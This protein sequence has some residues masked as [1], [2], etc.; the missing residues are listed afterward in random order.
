MQ[1]ANRKPYFDS[2]NYHPTTGAMWLEDKFEYEDLIFHIGARADYF[3]AHARALWDPDNFDTGA[4]GLIN[5]KEPGYDAIQNPDPNGDDFD[6]ELNPTGTEG[7]GSVDYKDANAKYQVSPR[8]G[9]SFAVSDKT[10]MYANYGHFFMMPELGEIYQNLYT[11]LTSGLP[12]V[13]NPDIEPQHTTAYEVGIKHTITP[14]LGFEISAFYKDVEN[15]LATRTYNTIFEGNVATVTFQEVEDFAKIKGMDFKLTFRNLYGFTGELNYSYLNAKG[16]GSSNREFYYLYIYEADRPLP[17][18]E[19]PLEFDITHSLKMNINYFVPREKGPQIWGM[20]PFAYFNA[21]LQAVINSGA[22]YTPVDIYDK[23]LELGSRRMPSTSRFDLRV[24]KFFP[25]YKKTV[26]S[27]YADIRNLFNAQNIVNVYPYTGL[28]DDPGR[29]PV[30][31][32]SR[33]Y[34][35]VG[36]TDPTTGRRITTPEEAYEAHMRVRREYYNRPYYYGIPRIVR[37][38][39]SLRF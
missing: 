4:D 5:S 8:F 22:P 19:Y 21:N 7:D 3:H 39:V 26:L 23:P 11:D 34:Q 12:L 30:F 36:R 9:I 2:Y 32:R 27:F 6:E 33:Y 31:E 20:Y 37:L 28:P 35:Y 18:K 25:I 1:F 10:A 17:S 29:A 14:D 15:L 13:G 24:E 38:G 16:T